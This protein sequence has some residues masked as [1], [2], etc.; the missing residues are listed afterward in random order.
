MGLSAQT[1]T[2]FANVDV[3][4]LDNASKLSLIFS[5]LVGGSIGSTAGGIKILRLLIVLR[6]L[7]FFIQRTALPAHAVLERQLS[8]DKL[9]A[10]EIERVL[11][12][13]LI[14]AGTVFGSWLPFLIMGY[15]PLDALFEVVSACSTTGLSTGISSPHLEAGLKWVLIIDMLLG[16]VEFLA[17]LLFMYPRTWLKVGSKT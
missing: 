4:A 7:Q 3:A 10:D 13:I 16:R 15:D 5:M 17:F 8:N 9:E 6:L 1:T 12:L 2:G 14:F 11:M